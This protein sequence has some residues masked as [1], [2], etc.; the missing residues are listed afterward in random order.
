MD[1]SRWSMSQVLELPDHLFGRRYAVGCAIHQ[2][3]VGSY[4]DVSEMSLPERCVIWEVRFAVL[5]KVDDLFGVS[6]ALGDQLPVDD[7]AFDRFEQLLPDIGYRTGTRRDISL[8]YR[9]SFE[10]RGLKIG[11]ETQGRRLVTRFDKVGGAPA[12]MEVELVVSSVPRSLPE[13][14]A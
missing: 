6:I 3:L 10:L 2:T 9:T 11:I 4:F 12:F 5:T 1:I 13:W 7:A 14:F 8:T